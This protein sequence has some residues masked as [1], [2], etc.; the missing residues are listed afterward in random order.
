MLWKK[1]TILLTVR[2]YITLNCQE[3]L[4]AVVFDPPVRYEN[5][6]FWQSFAY[7]GSSQ[8]W[9]SVWTSLQVAENH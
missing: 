4:K 9:Q 2:I 6:V 1:N 3:D 8:L 7:S 5:L